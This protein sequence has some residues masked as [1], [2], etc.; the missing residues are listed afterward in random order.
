[1]VS[2]FK[3]LLDFVCVNVCVY[4]SIEGGVEKGV[5]FI[6]NNK[7]YFSLALFILFVSFIQFYLIFIVIIL[8]YW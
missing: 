1:M 4:L 6:K 7:K 8:D 5:L 3:F 2:I